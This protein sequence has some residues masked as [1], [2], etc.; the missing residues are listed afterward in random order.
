MFAQ[1]RTERDFSEILSQWWKEFIQLQDHNY[2]SNYKE[3]ATPPIQVRVGVS[4]PTLT[5]MGGIQ[6]SKIHLLRKMQNLNMKPSI[7]K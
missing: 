1:H 2:L 3:I 4:T 6:H 5:W 7:K